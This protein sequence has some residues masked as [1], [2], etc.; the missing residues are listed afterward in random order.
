MKPGNLQSRIWGRDT[1]EARL[2]RLAGSRAVPANGMREGGFTMVEIALCLA[3]IAFAL[4]AIIGVL[5]IGMNVQKAN[6]EETIVNFDAKYLMDAIRS[7]AQGQD[8]LTNNI[9]SITNCIYNYQVI[10]G[11]TPR[12]NL[13]GSVTNWYN[14]FTNANGDFYLVYGTR[15]QT[16]ILTNGANIIGLLTT[17][18]YARP[19]INS[20]ANTTFVSNFVTA[21]FRALTGTVMDQG[22][23]QA[24]RDLAFGYRV[25]PEVVPFSIPDSTMMNP[26]LAANLQNSLYDV[27]LRFRW[28]VLP[29]GV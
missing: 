14:S 27:R 29:G 3:V 10:P 17:P 23:S 21:D 26:I 4:V 8:D 28:P 7:G 1:R 13:L 9:V 12:T 18:K 15:V 24:A 5:P 6:R 2:S 22:N 11:V 25:F 19:N 16:A 20:P